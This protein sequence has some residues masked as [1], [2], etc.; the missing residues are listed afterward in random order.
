MKA[1]RLGQQDDQVIGLIAGSGWLPLEVA[2]QAHARGLRVV[3][4]AHRSETD[5]QLEEL[6][7][8]FQWF[9]VGR[10]GAIA[11]FLRSAGARKV[12]L[13]GGI[14]K[15]K[16]LGNLCCDL[17]GWQVLWRAVSRHDDALLRAVAWRLER[18]GLKVYSADELLR[19]TQPGCGQLGNRGL[20]EF[21]LSAAID[22]WRVAK[23][24]GQLDVGQAVL[25]QGSMT[26][27]VEALEGTDR[28][29]VRSEELLRSGKIRRNEP[30]VLVKVS[31]PQQDTRMDLPAI[32]PETIRRLKSIGGTA[33]VLEAG[34]SLVAEPLTV[35]AEAN[36]ANIAVVMVTEATLLKT[37]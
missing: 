7:D 9:T 16:A 27:A 14:D 25:M 2:R 13:I 28:M 3:A 26:V 36:A 21:E 24:L 20:T 5:P 30:I 17:A 29:L 33:V 10:L 19:E 18:F 34:R 31:K 15:V 8:Q 32:G 23:T 12:M 22:G 4:A 1:K 6:C 37:K 35:V 11:R